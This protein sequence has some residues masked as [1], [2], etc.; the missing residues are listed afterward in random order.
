M[1][2]NI[3]PPWQNPY[4]AGHDE[5]ARQFE[6][7]YAAG[8]LPHAWLIA[9]I[10]GIGK[11]TLAW[12]FAHYVMSGGANPIGKLNMQH[13][14]ARLIAAEAHPDLFVLQRPLDERTGAL[15]D[16]IP[17]EEA[18]KIAPFLHMTA[19]HGGWRIAIVDE[20]HTLNRF[21]QNAILKVIEEP[22][23]KCLILL[24]VTTPGVLLPTI[25][26]RCRVLPLQPLDD[27]A[28]RAVLMRCGAETGDLGRVIA[29][30]S[31]SAGFALKML[32]TGSLPLYEE[33]L[34]L[35]QNLPELDMASAHRL[36]DRVGRKTDR[37]R[38]A[39]LA[40]LLT[41]A[42]RKAVRAQ[43]AGEPLADGFTARLAQGNRLD[44]TL[45]LWE[46]IGQT[47]ATTE[48]ASLDRKLAFLNAL[49]EIRRMAA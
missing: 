37:E 43:A 36:A 7:A 44:R 3:P 21:G 28:M 47:F 33:M 17:V 32:Q 24:T 30:S 41:E 19:S 26:S 8:R 18:R 45:Q 31:G 9:G 14:A 23:E 34:V 29:L 48:A 16:G 49:S 12:H 13:P 15:K 35:L 46:K 20:A 4:L 22:P 6:A 5:A 11:A 38:F 42:L 1:T 40:H 10:E 25:R 2:M 39:V 27:A